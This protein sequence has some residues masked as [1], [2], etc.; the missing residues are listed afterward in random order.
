MTLLQLLSGGYLCE[1]L[2]PPFTSEYLGMKSA[3]ILKA[4]GGLPKISD[5]NCVNF[6]AP[7][8]GIHRRQFSIPHPYAQIKLSDTIVKNWKT[9]LSEYDKSNVSISKPEIDKTKRRAIVYLDKFERFRE[10]CIIASS[11]KRYQLHLDIAKYFHSIYTHSIPWAIHTKSVAKRNRGLSLWGNQIDTFIRLA[12]SN[13]TKGIPVGTDTSRII[14]ELIGCEIDAAFEK[15]LNKHKIKINGYRFVDDCKYYFDTLAEAELALREYQ[16]ILTDYSLNLNDEKTI[17]KSSPC[18]FDIVWKL[19]L[20]SAPLEVAKDKNQRTDLKNYFNQL[21]HLANENPK[22]SVIKYGLKRISRL[23]IHPKN[24]DIFESLLY[25][26]ALHETSVIDIVLE[27]LFKYRSKLSKTGPNDFVLTLINE[28]LHKGHHYEVAWALWIARI[29]GLKIPS[30]IAQ[31]IID[32]RDVI[33][34]IIL[35][36][37]ISLK[38]IKGKVST[39]D[40]VNDLQNLSSLDGE[41]WLLAYE[42]EIKGWLPLSNIFKNP[43][44]DILKTNGVSFYLVPKPKPKS[45]SQPKQS[46]FSGPKSSLRTKLGALASASS[47]VTTVESSY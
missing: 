21:I 13:Q 29:F 19:P 28:N 9:I 4:M 22:D 17:I 7:K 5:L 40:L 16:K 23:P 38:Q 24:I 39:R 43:F 1:E 30:R 46:I 45:A 6:L 11:T 37:L 33:S 3:T 44:F 20:N 18:L 41:L 8:V 42:A 31:Q 47:K 27:L 34:I 14:A 2:P 26:V 35:L 32:S 25:Y 36:D 12:Q 15:A 10:V